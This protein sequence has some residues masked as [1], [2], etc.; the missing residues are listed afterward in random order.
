MKFSKKTEYVLIGLLITLSIILRLPT[1]PHEFGCDSFFI[2]GLANSISMF[3]SAKWILHPFS[4]FGWYPLSYPS[5]VPFILSGLSQSTGIDIEHIILIFAIFTGV[6]SIFT[7][8]IMALEIKNNDLFALIVAFCFSIAPI[9]LNYT[10]WTIST[11]GTLLALIPAFLWSLLKIYKHKS[12]LY[13][14]LSVVLL[15]MLATTHRSF[16][17]II[18]VIFAYFLTV[19]ITKITVKAGFLNKMPKNATFLVLLSLFI[20]F[21]FMP[22]FLH[23]YF[24]EKGLEVEVYKSGYLFSGSSIFTILLNAGASI[25]GGSGILFMLFGILGIF[26]LFKKQNRN[27]TEIFII[28]ALFF[29]LPFLPIRGY[30]RYFVILLGT[31]SI[32]FG[33]VWTIDIFK[34]KKKIL[35]AIFI[36][37]IL[38]SMI[39]SVFMVNH[40]QSVKSG[41]GYDLWMQDRTYNIALFIKAYINAN[42]SFVSSN[43]VTGRRIQAFSGMPCLPAQEGSGL[44]CNIII[45]NIIDKNKLEAQGIRFS[46]ISANTDYLYKIKNVDIYKVYRDFETLMTNPYGDDRSQKVILEYNTKYVVEDNR[47]PGKCTGWYSTSLF[48]SAFL[49]S[50]HEKKHRIYNNGLQ[51]LWYI[52]S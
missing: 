51:S 4:F 12:L 47:F 46:E 27:F 3:G 39:F 14:I 52:G 32:G 50:I 42:K 9:F 49:R 37:S 6:I 22:F 40:W 23:A 2:H 25:V 15:F 10:I 48:D 43:W 8:Y 1:V 13:G 17:F 11:R 45:Y 7:S 20:A 16:V 29:T 24:E 44:S 41:Y 19:I 26:Y 30:I 36:I 18:P 33:F 21:F 38:I 31:I 35:T 5:G 34:H 28:L